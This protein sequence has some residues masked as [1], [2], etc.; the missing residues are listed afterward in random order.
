MRLVAGIVTVLFGAAF[1]VPATAGATA[2]NGQ[3]AYAVTPV[4][5]RDGSAHELG[6]YSPTQTI[7]LAIGLRPPDMAAE[8]Q[9]LREIQDKS[10]PLFHQFLTT[11]QWTARFGP[12]PAAQQAVVSWAKGAGLTVTHLVREPPGRRPGGQRRARSRRR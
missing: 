12:T 7:R 1:A 3:T 11:S 10:S 4:P 2:Q 5:V 8:Q 6:P 9:F